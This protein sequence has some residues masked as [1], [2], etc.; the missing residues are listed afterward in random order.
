MREPSGTELKQA[1]QR[2]LALA[3]ALVAV[4][5]AAC[6]DDGDPQATTT[7]GLESESSAG[8]Q[9][10]VIKTHADL[11][12]IVDVGDVL[13][14]SS[15]GDAPF[16]PGGTFSGGHGS[17]EDGSLDRT[18]ECPDGTLTIAFTPGTPEGRTVTGPWRVLSG[19]GAFEGLE[20]SGRMETKF[21]AGAQAREAYT[22]TVVP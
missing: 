9:E 21:A 3:P 22:G 5:F 19:T 20:G 1:W 8:G 18:F 13:H 14:G 10:I 7:S 2:W 16:C 15:L 12:G 4:A 11:Q 6:G 17:V